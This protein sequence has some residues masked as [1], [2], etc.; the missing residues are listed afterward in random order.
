[1][2]L[3]GRGS[4]KVGDSFRV[5]VFTELVYRTVRRTLISSLRHKA[6]TFS[7]TIMLQGSIAVYQQRLRRHGLLKTLTS[8]KHVFQWLTLPERPGT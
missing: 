8:L 6:R 5:L 4:S 7:G 3:C 2:G 1:M